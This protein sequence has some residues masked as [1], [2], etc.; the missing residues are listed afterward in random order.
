MQHTI[1][2]HVVFSILGIESKSGQGECCSKDFM[3]QMDNC[4]SCHAPQPQVVL[5]VYAASL[6]KFFKKMER[7]QL[8]EIVEILSHQ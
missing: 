3:T 7:F 1:W 6:F 8:C 2:W 4:S 5:T